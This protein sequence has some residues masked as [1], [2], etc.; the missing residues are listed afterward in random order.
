MLGMSIGNLLTILAGVAGTI[1]PMLTSVIPPPY[2]VAASAVVAAISAVYH[3]F[4][5]SPSARR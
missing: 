5:P 3:L 1:A 2:N 4:A